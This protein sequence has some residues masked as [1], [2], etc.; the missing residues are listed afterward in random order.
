MST[1]RV[2]PS[3][4]KANA[5][6]LHQ[7]SGRPICEISPDM[8]LF[9]LMQRALSFIVSL[10]ADLTAEQLAFSLPGI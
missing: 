10:S 4:L 7:S 2:L 5:A 3:Y 1:E 8:H 9:T 6:R